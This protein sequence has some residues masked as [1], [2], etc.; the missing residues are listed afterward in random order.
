MR[1]EEAGDWYPGTQTQAC[2]HLG[3]RQHLIVYKSRQTCFVLFVF[4]VW[5]CVYTED[6]MCCVHTRR[7]EA[8]VGRLPPLLSTFHLNLELTE[9]A[10]WTAD[11]K[12]GMLLSLPPW[13][14]LYVCWVNSGPHVCAESALPTGPL[15]RTSY[16]SSCGQLPKLSEPWLVS[17]ID[18][19]TESR[20]GTQEK[21]QWL[22]T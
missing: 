19:K 8:Q 21:G 12:R 20:R 7:P 13:P 17:F 16:Q 5:M 3:N 10:R 15:G 22:G 2:S 14:A 1:H 6:N 11:S 18:R 4:S 9:S